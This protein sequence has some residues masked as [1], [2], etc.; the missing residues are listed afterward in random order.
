MTDVI[1]TRSIDVHLTGQQR[2]VLRKTV[3]S[4]MDAILKF[5]QGKDITRSADL[6]E[7]KQQLSDYYDLA[8]VLLKIDTD[9]DVQSS[10][11]AEVF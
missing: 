8:H 4:E 7:L 10:K 3:R 2:A 9:D 11:G 1:S 6:G 5:V